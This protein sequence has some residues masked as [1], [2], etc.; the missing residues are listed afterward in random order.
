MSLMPTHIAALMYERQEGQVT[1]LALGLCLVGIAVGGLAV[2]GA[3]TW[4]HKRTL[5]STADA[6]AVSGASGLDVSRFYAEGGAGAVLD[7]Q[8]VEDRVA[9]LLR[10]R[11]LG[12]TVRVDAQSDGVRVW[13]GSE[14]E[15]TFLSMV[16]IRRVPVSAEAVARPFFGNP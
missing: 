5:Q 9:R 13:L 6:A 15:T 10:Q 2:D 4:I 11:G 3:R 1:L 7:P 16:G 8:R 12:A 14:V